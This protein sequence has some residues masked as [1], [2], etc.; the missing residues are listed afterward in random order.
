MTIYLV[1]QTLVKQRVIRVEAL[2]ADAARDLAQRGYG[3]VVSGRYSRLALLTDEA[4]PEVERT[5]A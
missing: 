4:K 5:A 2:S 3:E 1:T